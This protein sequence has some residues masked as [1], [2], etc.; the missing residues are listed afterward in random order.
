M[1]DSQHIYIEHPLQARHYAMYGKHDDP[2]G[3]PMRLVDETYFTKSKSPLIKDIII[4]CT[5]KKGKNAIN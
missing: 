5:I 4:L 1:P 2:S 3:I